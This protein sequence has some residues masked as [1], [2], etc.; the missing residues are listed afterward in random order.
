MSLDRQRRRLR[1]NRLEGTGP[2]PP[3]PRSDRVTRIGNRDGATGLW[4]VIHP[5]GSITLNGIKTFNTMVPY[6]TVVL[7]VP[8]EDGFIALGYRS[9]E[10]AIAPVPEN[11]YLVVALIRVGAR[12]SFLQFGDTSTYWLKVGDNPPRLLF[13]AA[14]YTRS[15][16]WTGS[17]Q[18]ARTE[19]AGITFWSYLG[20]GLVIAD[21][22]GFQ[23]FAARRDVLI[24]GQGAPIAY[25]YSADEGISLSYEG[26]EPI[27]YPASFNGFEGWIPKYKWMPDSNVFSWNDPFS[28]G[29]FLPVPITA[30]FGVPTGIPYY[31][32]QEP[33]TRQYFRRATMF[34]FP[35]FPDD[36]EEVVRT[37]QPAI[38][39]AGSVFV[40]RPLESELGSGYLLPGQTIGP[41]DVPVV[42]GQGAWNVGRSLIPYAGIP[43]ALNQYLGR[44][45]TTDDDEGVPPDEL[46]NLNNSFR[47]RQ[48]WVVRSRP[49]NELFPVEVGQ[50]APFQITRQELIDMGVSPEWA[51]YYTEATD[52]LEDTPDLDDGFTATFSF[53]ITDVP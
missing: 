19:F 40:R 14:P 2:I 28:V 7:G 9:Q 8:R 33:F 52:L 27:S 17:G 51:T 25:S 6:G 44:P 39:Q 49:N 45:D 26:D 5:D 46:A 1:I 18:N 37:P 23:V 24:L 21:S 31:G 50:T 42:Y 4:E 30:T 12:E 41:D 13:E 47:S 22:V 48:P 16:S 43:L 3:A 29:T 11:P 36:L 20:N 15:T 32:E 35:V 10:R 38:A 53:K 34:P